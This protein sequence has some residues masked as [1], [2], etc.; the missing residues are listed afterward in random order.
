VGFDL[1][2]NGSTHTVDVPAEMPLLWV[3][4]D[5]LDL[6]GT[7][8]SCGVGRCGAC[9]V[10]VDDRPVRSCQQAVGTVAG[11]IVTIEGASGALVLRLRE[12]WTEEQVVQCGY[13][14]P[15]QIL[16]ALALLREHPR[17]TPEEIDT[18]FDGVLCRCATY[19]RII[20]AVGRVGA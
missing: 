9:T 18:A 17:P 13:C 5:V 2:V 12:A 7:K 15:A 14:Q 1:Q 16:T 8:Y 6:T 10:L 3:V 11:A 19:Q 20:A 4:R